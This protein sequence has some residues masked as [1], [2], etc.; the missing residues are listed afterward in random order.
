MAR[1]LL[2]GFLLGVL[3]GAVL[4]A[5]LFGVR[6]LLD[7]T[8]PAEA[9]GF[10]LVVAVVGGFLGGIVGAAVG[11]G[12]HAAPPGESISAEGCRP[13]RCWSTR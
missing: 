5:G 11:L 1:R 7:G 4:C 10:S 8:R 13:R 9:L 2:V 12:L 6:A 3:I